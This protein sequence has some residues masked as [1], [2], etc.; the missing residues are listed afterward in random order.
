MSL[1]TEKDLSPTTRG[2]VNRATLAG[3]SKNIDY[4][5]TLW[6][7][8]LKEEPLFLEGRQRLRVIEIQKYNALSTFGKQMLKTNIASVAM[9]LSAVAKKEPL[10][11]LPVAEE[12]LAIDPFNV[13][14]NTMIGD[15]GNAL[16]YPEFVAFGFETISQGRPDDKAS[17]NTLAEAYMR[18]QLYEK[19]EK[20][21]NR[22]L[23]I[24]PRDGE[25][26]SGLKNASAAHASKSGG[27]EAAA[28]DEDFR[29]A[30]KNKAEA[31]QLEQDSKVVKST[32]AIDNQ[33]QILYGKHQAEPTIPAHSKAIAQLFVQKNDYT[34]AIPFYQHAYE[35]GGKIDSSLEK[36]IGDLKMKKAAQELQQ[37]RAAVAAHTDP[38]SQAQAQAELE[39]KEKEIDLVRVELAEARVKAQPNEGEFRY[40]LGAA[41]FKVGQYKR[42]V[43]ELQQSLKQPSVRYQALNLMGQTFMK[44]NMLDFAIKQ[45]LTAKSE[46]VG[47]DELKK[48]IVYNLGLAYEAAKQ[49]DK[50]LDQFKEIYEY[51]MSYRDVAKRVED[52]YGQGDQAA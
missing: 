27:W 52:S 1:K 48:E 6:Q 47:M 40:D 9:K 30:L 2:L 32:E 49:P 35:A 5:I 51:D 26:L 34:N 31:D 17:L 43:E 44:R 33:I 18:L 22:I 20:T 28:K 25:A 10:E 38:D 8:I 41:L 11:Q 13:K 16:G 23:E 3:Q 45:L 50:A 4:A 39:Q 37:A 24:D 36:I 42:C 14:A 46:M 19:A 29:G 7:T 12:V 21:Y 15:A